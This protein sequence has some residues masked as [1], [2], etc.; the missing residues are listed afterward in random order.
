[1]AKI[2]ITVTNKRHNNIKLYHECQELAV[3]VEGLSFDFNQFVHFA[4]LAPSIV[5]R[6]DQPLIDVQSD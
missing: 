6:A 2:T 1:M 4:H 5:S 3:I